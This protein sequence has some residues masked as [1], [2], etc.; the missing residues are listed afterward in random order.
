ERREKVRAQRL[1]GFTRPGKF[2]IKPGY[3][4]RRSHPAIVG[5]DVLGGVIK[6]KYPVMRKDGRQVGTIHEIQREKKGIHEARLGD[7]V[8]V[9]IEGAIV[10][11]HIREGDTLY[12][13]IPR[14]HVLALK[15]ELRDL[16]SGDELAVMNE[17]IAIKQKQDSTYGVM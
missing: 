11:R 2:V 9:S 1:E 8:A 4:F 14:D 16:L 12:V 5:A 15:G 3:V 7:E 6:P 10:D 13:D 17:I